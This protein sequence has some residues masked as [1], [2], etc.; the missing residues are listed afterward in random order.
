LKIKDVP[1]LYVVITLKAFTVFD[2][3]GSLAFSREHTL[4]NAPDAVWNGRVQSE[5]A[6]LGIYA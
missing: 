5:A 1:L 3:W 2:R 4:T 6:A